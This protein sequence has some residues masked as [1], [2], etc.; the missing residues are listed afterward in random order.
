M[1]SLPLPP[2]LNTTNNLSVNKPRMPPVR[3]ATTKLSLPSKES[4]EMPTVEPNSKLPMLT[5]CASGKS[6]PITLP[7]W[8]LPTVLLT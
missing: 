7:A 8:K 3:I 2:K 4:E 6:V 5:L 1:L